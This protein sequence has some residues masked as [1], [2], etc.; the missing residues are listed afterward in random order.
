[1]RTVTVITTQGDERVSIETSATTWGELK[2]A[3]ND[4]GTFNA[5][6]AK[7]M[8]RGDRTPLSRDTDSIPSGSFSLFLTPEKIK[9]G[10]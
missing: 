2:R 4:E 6:S 8:I 10:K 5:S 9:S 7:A 3:I 1:M